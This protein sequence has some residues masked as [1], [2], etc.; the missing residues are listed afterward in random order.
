MR[1][2]PAQA[3]LSIAEL[4]Q[5]LAAETSLLIRQEVM[6]A[7]SE[8]LGTLKQ[9]TRPA[10][11]FGIAALFAIGAFA[12]LTTLFIAALSL[13]LPV[14]AAALIVTVIYGTIAAFAAMRGRSSL[15]KIGS[16]VPDQTIQTIKDDIT[17]VRAGIA[18]GR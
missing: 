4:L 17:E 11:D 14:W 13:A 8:V 3:D 15:T 7:R 1:N 2:A 10:A 12:T 6:L 18:R 5:K 9:A 16:P